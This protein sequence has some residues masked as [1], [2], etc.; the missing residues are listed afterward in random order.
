MRVKVGDQVAVLAGKDRGKRGKVLRVFPKD[1]RALVERLNLTKHF[2]RPTQTSRAGGI[3]EREM[4]L[5]LSKLAVVCPRCS[6]PTR[7]GMR[8][9]TGTAGAT[10][11]RACKQCQE[12]F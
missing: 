10:K 6:K 12:T 2:D 11:Q 5:P 7:V 1:D 9:S 3:V 8:L 4:P